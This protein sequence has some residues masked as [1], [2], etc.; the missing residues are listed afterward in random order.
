M[1]Q[2]NK[3]STAHCTEGVMT[4]TLCHTANKMSSL[5]QIISH[6]TAAS[7]FE[8]DCHHMDQDQIREGVFNTPHP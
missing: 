4:V 3:D 1:L 7:V 6:A 8:S 2:V 5:L